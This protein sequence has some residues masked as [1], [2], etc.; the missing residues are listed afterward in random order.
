[1][2]TTRDPRIAAI[3]AR[4]D[5]VTDPELDESVVA[6]GFVSG[7]TVDEADAVTIGFRLPTY[8]CSANFAW[9]MAEDMRR[10]VAAL[11][12]VRSVGVVLDDHMFADAINAALAGGRS[13]R[14]AFGAE[15]DQA[16]LDDVRGAFARKAFGRRQLALLERLLADGWTADA[17]LTLRVRGLAR[18]GHDALVAAYLEKRGVP[19]PFGAGSLAFVDLEDRP[20]APAALGRHLSAL[21]GVVVNM[22][23]N[24]ALCRGLLAAR[25]NEA[26]QVP[27]ASTGAPELIDFIR[28]ARAANLPAG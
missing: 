10:S 4:L 1:M 14:D 17:V 21:R 23:F 2:G 12:W 24:G 27:P 20:L 11:P 19:G 22:E 8:W 6:L 15:A 5:R 25:Y 13:F 7:I 9:I 28:A 26:E 16:S 18:L 3:T